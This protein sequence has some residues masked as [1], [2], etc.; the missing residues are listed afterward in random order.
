MNRKGIPKEIK[1][2]KDREENSTEIFWE[3]TKGKFVLVSYVVHTKSKGVKNILLLSTQP[4]LLGVTK[5]DGKKKPAIIKFYD[6]TKGGT[7]IMDQRMDSYTTS[8]KSKKWTKKTFSW[9]L[10]VARVNAQTILALVKGQNPRKADSFK[11][12]W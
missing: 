11:F 4:P 12:S 8:S 3:Q 10:D 7:D 6:F 5:D 2:T 1:E 9:M